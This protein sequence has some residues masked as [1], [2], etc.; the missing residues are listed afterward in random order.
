M[1]TPN[2]NEPALPQPVDNSP[3]LGGDR[4]EWQHAAKLVSHNQ[5]RH[6]RLRLQY[7]VLEVA[8]EESKHLHIGDPFTVGRYLFRAFYPIS[9]D[10]LQIER[11]FAAV[12]H[13]FEFYGSVEIINRKQPLIGAFDC[14]CDSW[15]ADL[16]I[17][18]EFRTMF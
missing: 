7:S 9:W 16:L 2:G 15:N 11:Q 14:T 13:I 18:G 10:F 3:A 12:I 4:S 17:N 5:M 1:T 8:Y 6:I